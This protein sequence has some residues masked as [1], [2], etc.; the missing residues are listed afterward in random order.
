[1][2]VFSWQFQAFNLGKVNS[3]VFQADRCRWKLRNIFPTSTSI[4]HVLILNF[5]TKLKVAGKK[6][7]AYTTWLMT[8]SDLSHA[9]LI[10][11]SPFLTFKK[12]MSQSACFG[13]MHCM[14]NI[15][16]F[17]SKTNSRK[18]VS[19][20]N[21]IFTILYFVFGKSFSV[22]IIRIPVLTSSIN[23]FGHL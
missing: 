23:Y 15:H 14:S 18:R 22:K 4:W 3:A 17:F 8:L 16:C 10:S 13:L 9:I 20:C 7:G 6:K 12:R 1:M 11:R 21:E 5:L 2:I 19:L